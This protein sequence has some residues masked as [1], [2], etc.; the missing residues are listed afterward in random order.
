MRQ[1]KW[2]VA[3]A[4]TTTV[5]LSAPWVKAPTVAQTVGKPPGSWCPVGSAPR[6][7]TGLDRPKCI[8]F[9]PV[10]CRH[11]FRPCLKWTC[12]KFNPQTKEPFKGPKPLPGSRLR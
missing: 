7:C 3:A 9:A 11:G 6:P 10:R 5:L 2:A 8:Q 4:A 12:R 1:F